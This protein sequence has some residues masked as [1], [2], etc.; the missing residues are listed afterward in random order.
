MVTFSLRQR[1][2]KVWARWRAVLRHIP[3]PRLLLL[4]YLSYITLG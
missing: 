1:F 4:G 3:A 2:L